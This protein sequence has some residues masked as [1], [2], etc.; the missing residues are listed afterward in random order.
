MNP[1]LLA[2]RLIILVGATADTNLA[3]ERFSLACRI[4][5]GR[6][7]SLFWDS[8]WHYPDRLAMAMYDLADILG[9]PSLLVGPNPDRL[10]EWL[11]IGEDIGSDG[12]VLYAPTGLGNKVFDISSHGDWV[13]PNHLTV[14]AGAPRLHL[15]PSRSPFAVSA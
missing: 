12:A 7:A 10:A 11:S 8:V 9:A 6:P 4:N 14:S 3:A 13:V 1:R 15:V 2:K 5:L